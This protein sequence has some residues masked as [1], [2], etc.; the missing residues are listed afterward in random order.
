[1]SLQIRKL[2]GDYSGQ[3]DCLRSIGNIYY[4]KN[5]YAEALQYYLSAAP[6]YE[7]ANDVKGL[8]GD[9]IWIG[10]VF[11]EGLRQFDKAV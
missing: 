4:D 2:S 7:K 9:Y 5:D 6:F 10:N 1:Q 3:G 11:N 8:S